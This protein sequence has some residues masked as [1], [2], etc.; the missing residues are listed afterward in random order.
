MKTKKIYFIIIMLSCSLSLSSCINRT[1]SYYGGTYVGKIKNEMPHGYG[2]L[3]W[4]NGSNYKGE[5][6][7]GTK[8][9]F[10]ILTS[11]N[12]DTYTGEFLNDDFHGYGKGI[13]TY[14][15]GDKYEGEFLDGKRHGYGKGT[16][17]WAN[18]DKYEGEFLN[19]KRHGQ[20]IMTWVDSN[21][22]DLAAFKTIPEIIYKG[23]FFED[24]PHGN[25][26]VSDTSPWFKITGKWENGNP[27]YGHGFYYYTNVEEYEG[28][29]YNCKPHGRG[30]RSYYDGESYSKYDGEWL[31]G[32]RDGMGMQVYD[33]DT[34]IERIYRGKFMNDKEGQGT[35]E[36]NDSSTRRGEVYY[37]GSVRNGEPNGYGTAYSNDGRVF[38]G[39]FVNGKYR[40]R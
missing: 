31:N 28:E 39:F 12:G 26:E 25:G 8:T 2:I 35:L 36:W 40:G 18:G 10:G 11:S 29:F 16:S 21:K 14:D 7:D 32:K 4:A 20:G 30:K 15:N 23:E 34:Y 1:I 6:L 19:G 38:T 33:I 27:T 22:W 17:S 37:E 24:E 9:G 13:K 5:W 3:T